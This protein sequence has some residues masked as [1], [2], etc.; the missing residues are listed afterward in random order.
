MNLSNDKDRWETIE[1]KA[2]LQAEDTF[3]SKSEEWGTTI[4]RQWEVGRE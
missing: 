3:V 1:T 2:K 4:T